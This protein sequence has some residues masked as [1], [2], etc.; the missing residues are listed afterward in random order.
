M[1]FNGPS[2]EYDEK[3]LSLLSGKIRSLKTKEFSEYPCLP[4][5]LPNTVSVGFKNILASD[6]IEELKSKV[7]SC[8]LMMFWCMG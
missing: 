8:S 1:R 6:L 7:C 4:T 2:L 5:V 3:H